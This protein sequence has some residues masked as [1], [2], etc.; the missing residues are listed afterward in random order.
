MKGYYRVFVQ[1][2]ATVKADS[3][4]DAEYKILNAIEK[5]KDKSINVEL[6]DVDGMEEL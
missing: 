1:I 4:E 2:T 6:I 5:P 3:F